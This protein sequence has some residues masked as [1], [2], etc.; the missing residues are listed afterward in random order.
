M[1]IVCQPVPRH[2]SQRPPAELKEK[3]RA[4]MPR[5]TAR[6]ER[7]KTLPDL[8]PGLDVGHRVRARRAAER[9]LVHEQQVR[10]RLEPLD[11]VVRPDVELRGALDAPRVGVVAGCR[12]R[13]W[14]CPSPR[15]PTT[16]TRRPS[17][18]RTV[19]FFRLCC[20]RADDRDGALGAAERNEARRPAAPPRRLGSRGV[21]GVRAAARS[22]S[23]VAEALH[24]RERAR[25]ALEEQLAAAAARARARGRS[26]GRPPRS[27]PDRARRRRRCC[28]GRPAAAG[29]RAAAA[30][31]RR[32]ARSSARRGRRACRSARRRAPTARP[33]RCASPPESVRAGARERQVVEADVV[34]VAHP[35]PELRDDRRQP[36]L[37]GRRERQVSTNQL[38][39]SASGRSDELGDRAAAEAH[40]ERRAAPAARRGRRRTACRRGSARAARGRGSCSAW[41]RASRRSRGR[42]R[43]RRAPRSGPRARA[44]RGAR[45][46]RPSAPSSGGRRGRDRRRRT[47]RPACSR[48]RPAAPRA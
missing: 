14:T 19:R 25:R 28:R 36:L 45:P 3:S 34:H 44:P 30:C 35:R 46:G 42:R 6:A 39:R 31:P 48:A 4:V 37:L 27:P 16:A 33:I 23:P 9:A 8:V 5:E 18:S 1:S 47:R 29:S 13:A 24:A 7:A 21:V 43:N 32:A 26:R 17:G 20:A 41:S 38:S 2:A 15:R 10:D 22:S 11:P 12:A 40:P